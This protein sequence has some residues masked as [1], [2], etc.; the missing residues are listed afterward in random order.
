MFTCTALL[1]GTPHCVLTFQILALSTCPWVP[2]S[3]VSNSL[4]KFPPHLCISLNIINTIILKSLPAPMHRTPG[5][6]LPCPLFLLICVH[7][8]LSPCVP[9]YFSLRATHCDCRLVCRNQVKPQMMV[10]S[11]GEDLCLLLPS[12]EGCEPPKVHLN[13]ISDTEIIQN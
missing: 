1:T 6:C 8:V 11:T 12:I 7:V 10:F 4:L 9:G 3:I 5:A 2:S 13:P